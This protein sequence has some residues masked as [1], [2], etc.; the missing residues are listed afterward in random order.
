MDS[1][2]K[3]L[4]VDDDV[5]IV[6]MIAEYMKLYNF[7]PVN[8]YSGTDALA[9]IDDTFSLVLLDI[10][11]NDTDGVTICEK[12]RSNY[13]IPII[14]VS[15]NSSSFDKIKAL[16]AGADDYI[17]KPFDPLELVARVKSH[18]RRANRYKTINAPSDIIRFD[19]IT[20]YKSSY[21]VMKNDEEINLSNTEFRLLIYFIENKGIALE[22]KKILNDV[23]QSDMYDE[24]I[25]NTYVKRIREKLCSGTEKYIKSVRSIGYV[26]DAEIIS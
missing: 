20:I 19:T 7:L 2:V 13:D 6:K 5:R 10:N 17:V 22:R 16:G 9:Y 3:I 12:I 21:K 8:A 23:W 14:M 24:S 11:M 18:I 15:A 25:I 4:I 1:K 26:F